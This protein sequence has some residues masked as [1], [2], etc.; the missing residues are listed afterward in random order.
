MKKLVG[1]LSGLVAITALGLVLAHCGGGDDGKECSTTADCAAKGANFYCDPTDGT[2]KC[3]P[4]CTGKCCGDDGCGGT[5]ENN[6]PAGQTCNANSCACEADNTC[7]DGDARCDG[8]VIQTCV[9]GAWENGTDCATNNQVCVNGQCEASG[10]CTEGDKRCNGDTVQTC[11][12]NNT[13]QD[14]TDCSANGQV[15]VD[16]A[17]EASG[18]TAGDTRC[19]GNVVQN[20]VAGTWEDGTDCTT[21][22]KVCSNGECVTGGTCTQGDTRCAGTTVQTCSANGTWDDTMNCAD[23]G[24]NCSNGA[25]V[26]IVTQDE[27][28]SG[29][30][31]TD[32]SGG[33]YMGCTEG[34]QIPAGQTTGC[35]ENTPCPANETCMNTNNGTVCVANCGTCDTD[36]LCS[37]VGSNGTK[38]CLDQG[39]HIPAGAQTGCA[40][41]GCTGNATCWCLNQECTDSVCVAN[42]TVD[43]PCTSGARCDGDTVISCVNGTWAAGDDC[44]ANDQVCF[45][46]AC[47]SN[48]LCPE[49]Q[50]CDVLAGEST[51]CMENGNIPAGNQTGCGQNSRCTGNFSCWR[52]GETDT[53]CIEN[54]GICPDPQVCIDVTVGDGTGTFACTADESGNVPADA[55]TGCQSGGDCNGNASCW[56]LDESCSQTV[57]LF[58]CSSPH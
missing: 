43:G 1:T 47:A 52:T 19:N 18:C 31:C 17:C 46:G 41:D 14:G 6:C 22:S 40:Q 15:C 36:L 26:D 42:C 11:D 55:Q 53:I 39:G 7:T 49:G 45:N 10:T 50:S 3:A 27:C 25:C 58:N 23:Q 5:C 4:S 30:D 13:W 34:G 33:G 48:A 9:A 20:C 29:Q 28:P 12:A 16:G 54:C 57:C 35:S 38:G 8:N 2:C 51:G 24:K 32:V 44:S 37:V 21:E 56:C